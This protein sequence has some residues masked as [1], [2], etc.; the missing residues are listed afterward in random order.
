M[1]SA[2]CISICSSI[3]IIDDS[4]FDYSP[5]DVPVPALFLQARPNWKV[6]DAIWFSKCPIG[7]NML[8]KR[9]KEM[10]SSAGLKGNFSNH[11]MRATAVTRMYDAGVNEKQIMKRSGHRSVEGVRSYQREEAS[12]QLKVSNI[13]ASSRTVEKTSAKLTASVHE[14]RE[15]NKA[16]SKDDVLLVNACDDYER[17]LSQLNVRG[18][19]QGA[20]IQTVNININMNKN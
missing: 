13:L 2:L 8:Q 7:H 12:G 18:I 19:L 9:F 5:A 10:C 6:G 3:W 15:S 14:E 20:N 4:Y 1:V 17:S 16:K 11:S